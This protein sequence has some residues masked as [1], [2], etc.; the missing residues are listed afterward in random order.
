MFLL[1]SFWGIWNQVVTSCS[2][3]FRGGE[4][5]STGF[6]RRW[7]HTFCHQ[8]LLYRPLKA[9]IVKEMMIWWNG[10][11]MIE[12]YWWIGELEEMK[13]N[14]MKW[15]WNE[16]KWNEMKWNEMKWNEMK[17]NEMKW[18]EMDDE[19]DD[20]MDE[21]M[22]WWWCP[23]DDAGHDIRWSWR[24]CLLSRMGLPQS[25]H[26][27]FSA[28]CHGISLSRPCEGPLKFVA[29]S[30]VQTDRLNKIDRAWEGIDC[31]KARYL[32]V[33]FWKN[34]GFSLQIIH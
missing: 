25:V 1:Y 3:G 13:W 27:S 21:L 31:L 11:L 26:L 17:W 2:L 9:W 15:W 23:L 19:M 18:N 10:E 28:R 14:E 30:E 29:R 34:S 22:N 33:F 20:E 32:G 6:F 12:N 24:W 8:G 16:M 4:L 5:F 7:K